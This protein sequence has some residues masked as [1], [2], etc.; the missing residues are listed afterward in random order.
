MIFAHSVK[1]KMLENKIKWQKRNKSEDIQCDVFSN[2]YESHSVGN[3]ENQGDKKLYKKNTRE[4]ENL[5]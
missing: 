2:S 3:F 4:Y 1:C 5:T